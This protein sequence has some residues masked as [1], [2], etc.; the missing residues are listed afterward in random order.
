MC[1]CEYECRCISCTYTFLQV[2]TYKSLFLFHLSTCRNFY[3]EPAKEKQN[4][5]NWYP[6][7]Q[8]VFAFSLLAEILR[9]NSAS[10]M[11]VT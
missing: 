4:T 7:H 6:S 2:H 8:F 5:D 11:I 3:K 9:K 1:V 10:C